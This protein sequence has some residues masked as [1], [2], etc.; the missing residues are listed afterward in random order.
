MDMCMILGDSTAVGV[1]AYRKECVRYAKVGITSKGW[2][3]SYLNTAATNISFDTVIISLGSNDHRF[4]K[5]EDELRKMRL[6]IKTKRVYWIGA[7]AWRRP[8]AQAAIDKIAQE[9]GDTIIMR[10]RTAVAGDG[11]HPSRAE[12]ERLARAAR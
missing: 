9:F 5:T 6:A 8:Q 1:A 10:S 11:V 2:N 12:Y 4:I 3:D 7:G